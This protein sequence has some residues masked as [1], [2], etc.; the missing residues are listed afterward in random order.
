MLILHLIFQTPAPAPVWQ[1][2]EA[3]AAAIHL[4]TGIAVAFLVYRLA[5]R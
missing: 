1:P 5:R 3:A 2:G 4:G